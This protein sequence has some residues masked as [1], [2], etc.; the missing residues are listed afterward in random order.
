MVHAVVEW[1]LTHQSK[2]DQHDEILPDGRRY[3]LK[4]PPLGLSANQVLANQTPDFEQR[5]ENS[6]RNSL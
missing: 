4:R 6:K 1:I 3:Q 2:F 5:M